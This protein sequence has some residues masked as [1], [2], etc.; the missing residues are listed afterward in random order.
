MAA[1]ENP[2]FAD[3]EKVVFFHDK[4]TGL[5]AIIAVHSTVLGPAAGGCRLWGYRSDDEALS[6]VL[7]LS[8]A[9]SYKNAMADLKFGGG[10][11]VI[12]KTEDF[13]ESDALYE[14]FGQCVEELGGD[15]VTAEDVGI[16]VSIMEMIARSTKH[17][18]GLPKKEGRAGG[19]PSPMTS[20]GIFKGIEAAAK[21]KL[22]RDSVD[23]MTVAIQGV[24]HVG[25]YLS[26]YL[27]EAG[28]KLLVADINAERVKQVCEEFGASE[29]GLREILFQDVDVVAPC[30]LGA[31]LT[32]E[33]IPRLQAGIIAGGANNQLATDADGKRLMDAGILYAPDYVIN[34]G[35]IINVACEYYGGVEDAEVLRQV[36]AI[37]PRLERIFESSRDTGEATNVIA[38]N[39]ARTIIADKAAA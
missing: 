25:Y 18:S 19:D 16:S 36:A 6:D 14:K 22:D 4:A 5:K 35:G 31:I 17:V 26:K 24:G 2:A 15:Y 30:A 9:M 21:F 8:K 12:I 33:T 32:A 39:L 7:R 28:A 37:G 38:D 11:A 27:S 3:H 29:V 34:G 1:F 20:F 23:G 10:K 13:T